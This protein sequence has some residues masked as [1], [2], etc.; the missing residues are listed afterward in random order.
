VQGR[1]A[2]PIHSCRRIV[3]PGPGLQA[4][5]E[6][7]PPF[8]A[9]GAGRAQLSTTSANL[10]ELGRDPPAYGTVIEY[11]VHTFYDR[12]ERLICS[13][14]QALPPIPPAP[15][16]A[17]EEGEGN[18]RAGALSGSGSSRSRA[19]WAEWISAST[20]LGQPRGGP[21]TPT[22]EPMP[23]TGDVRPAA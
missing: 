13:F 6:P 15:R 4:R 5:F 3:R 20:V 7:A 16:S 10:A 18:R 11:M 8:L 1:M 19:C 23:S 9:G 2:S 21:T 14:H 17:G 12:K 22:P